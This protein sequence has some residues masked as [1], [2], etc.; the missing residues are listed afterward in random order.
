TFY[1]QFARIIVKDSTLLHTGRSSTDDM[2]RHFHS[3][4]L[5]HGNFEEVG[6]QHLSFDWVDLEIAEQRSPFGVRLGARDAERN[7]GG[8]TSVRFQDFDQWFRLNRQQKALAL[9]V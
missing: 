6:M 1:K 8:A 2:H 7:Q 9:P 4:R 3:N 5:I